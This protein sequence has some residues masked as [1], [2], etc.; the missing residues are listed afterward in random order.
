MANQQIPNLPAAISLGGAEEVEVVQ[1]GVS[2]RA[3]T[4]QIA[5]LKGIG[6]T[7]P[8]GPTGN[9]GPT[10]PTG[11]V[12]PTGAFGGPTG[13]TG[14]AGPT[15]PTGAISTVPGPT[16]PTGVAGPTGPTGAASTVAGPTGPT[17]STGVAGPT[18][19]T[20]ANS[21]VAGPTGPTGAQGAN[22]ISSGLVL[23]IDSAS[24]TSPVSGTLPLIPNTGAQQT[25]T[26][27]VN[28]SSG[29]QIGSFVTAAGVPGVTVVAGGNWNVWLYASRSGAADVR[30][31]AVIQEVAS[32]G[33][34]VLQTLVNGSYA[35]GTAVDTGTSSTFD[36]SA[37]VTA[38]TLASTSSRIK[39]TLYAQS[40]SGSPTLSTYYRDGTISYLVSSISANVAGPTGPT[41]PTGAA[42]SVAGPTGPTGANGPST[43]T[44]GTTTITSGAA[45]RL[46]YDNGALVGETTGITTNGT[47]LTLAGTTAALSSVLT[48][49]AEVVTISATAATG[50]INYDVTTQSVLY[51]TTAASANWT[52][53]FRA[54]SGTSLNTALVTGQS[55]TVAFLVTQGSTA[56]YNS[57]VQV[58]GSSVTPKWQGGTA[59]TAG[60]A[61]GVDIYTFTIVK[62]ASA[63]FTIFA[64]QTQF[65]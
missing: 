59:P 64:S 53:N 46:L 3:T 28:S 24:G 16:G 63:T 51:Y 17:G 25:V 4:Q 23:Y 30:Y 7:G 44:V 10:G 8:T 36:F 19:P 12:G 11:N 48:N 22:G 27:S 37:Y 61:S 9:F 32:D 35:S 2:R 54:S 13:P 41:G 29:T 38:T 50:T 55:I 34:T 47:T 31:W 49:A 26:T 60:N 52:V 14:V 42:S 57:A 65:K 39:V 1:A 5:N 40:V 18:G 33:T 15:G 45:T 6:P 62:T 58:D 21:T 56:Y 43:I 20:G